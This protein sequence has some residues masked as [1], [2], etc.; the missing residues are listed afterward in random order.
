MS[1]L[2]P[3]LLFGLTAVS[4]PIIIHLLNRRR[5][6]KVIWAAMRFVRVSVEQNQKRM[7]IEDLILLILRCVMLFL[8]ALAL[9]RPAWRD[10]AAGAFG[11]AKVS[12]VILLDN[13]GSMGMHDGVE[14]RFEQARKA[15][16]Q[17]VDS[18]P[19]GSAAAVF[20][21]S[22]AAQPLIEEPTHDLNLVRKVLRE[23]P[24]SDRS[25]DLYPPMERAV[26]SLKGRAAIQKEIYLVTDG[27]ANGWRQLGDIQGLLERTRNEGQKENLRVHLILVGRPE[28]RNIA[29]SELTL[30]TGLSPVNRPLRFEVSVANHGLAAA[31]NVKVSLQVDEGAPVDQVVIPEIPA[32]GTRGVSLFARLSGEGWHAVTA[33]IDSDRLAFD[34]RRTLAVRAIKD[35]HVLLVDGD[36]GQEARESETFFL[37]HALTPVP[38]AEKP[39]YFIKPRVIT[40]AELGGVR[41]DDFDVVVLANVSEIPAARAQ[42]LERY[43]RRGGG[44]MVFPGS[45]INPAFYNEHLAKRVKLLPAMFGE[46]RGDEKQDRQFA[47]FHTKNYDHPIVS[48]WRNQSSGTLA[49][50]RVYR[51]FDLQP[52]VDKETTA[53][54]A[55]SSTKV[56]LRLADNSPAI[57]EKIYGLGRV[58]QFASTAD[59]A[60]NDLSVRPAFVPLLHR[61]LASMVLL[62]DETANLSV[63]QPFVQRVNP[64]LIGKDASVVGPLHS[65]DQRDLARVEMVNGLPLLRYAR[66]DKGGL[67]EAT[68]SDPPTVMKF[69]AQADP[70]ESSLAELSEPDLEE[71]Q[72]V[73]TVTK[74][75]P[76]VALR[77]VVEKQRVGA[78]FWFPL[79]ILVL[80]LAGAETFLAQWFSRSK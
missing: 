8:L 13:S 17:I 56:V 6:Q 38:M 44:L 36:P 50:A 20:L 19:S 53:T 62:Q 76:M 2:N 79:A 63:G 5:F 23:A 3:F 64:E 60:W 78:E 28:L 75:G 67:Y 21:A 32:N 51:Y 27:Q 39:D 61:C 43:V 33:H 35:V 66:T 37:G 80:I 41:F 68:I 77:Q 65:G 47:S 30:A 69:A 34:D 40:P 71:I 31:E 18:L 72:K 45:K 57:V 54:N 26:E 55:L 74:W 14:T 25:S 73:A 1:F 49:S 59:I 58:I 10:T 48:L 9:A 12:A 22:D 7:R 52:I 16:E 11:L 29:V 24:L 70:K 42:L 15:A 4:V 46:P